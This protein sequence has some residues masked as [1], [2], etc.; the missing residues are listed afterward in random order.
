VRFLLRLVVLQVMSFV[1]PEM[2]VRNSAYNS[3]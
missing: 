3:D 1:C 2:K